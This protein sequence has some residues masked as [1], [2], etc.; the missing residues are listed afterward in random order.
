[1]PVHILQNDGSYL[2]P[3]GISG[4]TDDP[5]VNVGGGSDGYVRLASGIIVPGTAAQG[6]SDLGLGSAATQAA[7]A[8][9]QTANNLSDVTA[10]TARTNLGLGTAATHPAGDFETAG[11]AATE[12]TR[13][14]AA[15]AL[16]APKASPTFTGTPAAPTAAAA[17]STTQVATTAMV[18]AAIA[19][20]A[21][22]SSVR[23]TTD[24]TARAS[25]TT[26][27]ADDQLVLPVV[28][29]G[30]YEV[31]VNLLVGAANAVMDA[32]VGFTGPAGAAFTWGASGTPNNNAAG[33]GIA[34]LANSPAVMKTISDS[35]AFGTA[36]GTQGAGFVGV[37]VVSSTAGNL[38]V[39]WA[40]NTSDA[41]NL[42]MMAG[43][44]IKAVKIG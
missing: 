19:A 20:A 42:Q 1:M 3:I 23:R 33:Y 25:T 32:K 17:T 14:L 2:P 27:V 9:A 18:Q 39:T 31:T 24:S 26:L 16:L 12:Q 5:T 41:G 6:R 36:A 35:Q 38:T 4:S 13:A 30:I 37:L 10:S 44:Y 34:T 11:A 43:S 8:F 40:Q 7:T 15:E 21:V 28:A 29:N 22:T